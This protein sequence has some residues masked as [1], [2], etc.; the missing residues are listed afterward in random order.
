MNG[1]SWRVKLLVTRVPLGAALGVVAL[2]GT[3]ALFAAPAPATLRV[4]ARYAVPGAPSSPT[5]VRW[6]SENSVYLVRNEHGVAEVKLAPGLPVVRTLVPNRAMGNLSRLFSHVAASEGVL[7]YADWERRLGWRPI[8]ASPDGKVLFTMKHVALTEGL[9]LRGDRLLLLGIGVEEGLEDSYDRQ[10][11]LAG[12]GKLNS[13]FRDLKPLRLDS[14]GRGAPHY[15]RCGILEAGGTRFLQD[16]S[17]FL[18]PAVEPGAFLYDD[19]GTLLRSWT[20]ADL[21]VDDLCSGVTKEVSRTFFRSALKSRAWRSSHRLVDA[22]LP[23]PQGPAVIVRTMVD[24]RPSWQLKVLG[25]HGILTFAIPVP[26][27]GPNDRLMA[28]ARGGS[29]VL[30]RTAQLL[31]FEDEFTPAELLVMEL[32]TR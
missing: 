19:E 24:G 31:S 32:P 16:G 25:S 11:G 2:A 28:D 29:I 7:A 23:L 8:Q 30:L 10:G 27:V 18:V 20:N 9:D 21:G 4:V 12:F 13:D 14:E 3:L 22:V 6:A 1:I 17:M 15:S 5:D 26:N